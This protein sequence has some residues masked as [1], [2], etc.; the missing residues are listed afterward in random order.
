MGIQIVEEQIMELWVLK[1]TPSPDGKQREHDITVKLAGSPIL[2][3]TYERFRDGG[4]V[5]H[6]YATSDELDLD[7]ITKA[8]QMCVR[9]IENQS[10]TT[11]ITITEPRVKNDPAPL[12]RN[13]FVLRDGVYR[14]EFRK[15]RRFLIVLDLLPREGYDYP[16]VARLYCGLTWLIARMPQAWEDDLGGAPV[17]LT[18]ADASRRWMNWENLAHQDMRSWGRPEAEKPTWKDEGMSDE[19]LEAFLVETGYHYYKNV[20]PPPGCEILVGASGRPDK[21]ILQAMTLAHDTGMT[22]VF[23]SAKDGTGCVMPCGCMYFDRGQRIVSKC[24]K[25]S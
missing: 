25:H 14:R 23:N 2:D 7:D 18:V 1:G 20:V 22:T 17:G 10:A 21:D 9:H 6:M 8:F 19:E 24:P 16:D 4:V 15:T 3:I 12:L 13:G 5:L 11:S